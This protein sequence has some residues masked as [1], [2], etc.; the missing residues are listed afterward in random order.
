MKI[1]FSAFLIV[2]SFLTTPISNART[3]PTDDSA[4]LVETATVERKTVKPASKV[5]APKDV[6]ERSIWLKHLLWEAGFRGKA[7]KTAWAV[8]MRESTGRPMAHNDNS[9]TMDNSY[10][11]F[12][13][14][15]YGDLGPARREK[16]DI[17][18]NTD[19]FNPLLNA[20]IA[21]Y[22]TQKGTNW[23]SWDINSNGYNGGVG[24]AKF[25]DW[26]KRYPKVKPWKTN[27][28]NQQQ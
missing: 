12:Q 16:F 25:K 10:G 17:E 14:N 11:I 23:Y 26:L 22:M 6:Q 7:L 4:V 15:M 5:K 21:F 28:K 18:K 19:L 20:E 2:L 13:I 27:L 9:G 3:A 24:E 8:A 1:T